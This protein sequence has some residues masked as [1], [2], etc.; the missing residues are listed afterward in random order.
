[1]TAII[2]L[3]I[4]VFIVQSNTSPDSAQASPASALTVSNSTSE[5]DVYY[6]LI[7]AYS[8]SDLLQ[9][10]F[11]IDSTEF[12]KKL[13]DIGFYVPRCAQSNYDTTYT[14]LTSSLNM[15]YLD[16]LGIDQK[17]A[18]PTTYSSYIHHSLV[19]KSFEELGYQTVTFKLP[20]PAIDI[21]D[22]TYYFDY[23]KNASVLDQSSALNFQYL[24]LNTTIFRPLI[25]YAES[26]NDSS[27]ASMDWFRWLNFGSSL[28]SREYK[29][30]QQNVFALK[31]LTS[32]P[33]LPGK[34]FV[35]AHLLITHQPYV[36]YPDGTFHAGLQQD[37]AA[38]R[39]QIL[40]ANKRIPEVIE[41][42]LAQSNP[43]PIII[44]QSDHS[45]VAGENRVKILNAYY[46]PE[47]S[48]KGLYDTITPVNTFR[49]IFNTYFGGK[50]EMLPDV[51]RYV[52]SKVN[53][54]KDIREAPSSCVN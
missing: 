52:Y 3:E 13:T 28:D 32:I 48:N 21:S 18:D 14:S 29:Q 6:I 11:G 42:I 53:N 4:G 5:R 44:V 16:A 38:Y 1:M 10:Q 12:V 35:Y 2:L 47:S 41:S 33:Q 8:R 22:S 9:D 30:Y 37:D 17:Q 26:K 15:N 39:D 36:F 7:D 54:K 49:L 34:K 31:S 25:A 20:H 23:F 43:K 46:L 51:S 45:Y 19:R 40:F 50:Y 27:D 24:F